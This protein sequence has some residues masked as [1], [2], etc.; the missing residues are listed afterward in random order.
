MI[1]LCEQTLRSLKGSTMHRPLFD[2]LIVRLAM[3][4]QFT[5]LRDLLA[6]AS[7][8][9]TSNPPAAGQKKK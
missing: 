3:S 4:D 7:A 5:A 9:K 6:N 8:A 1:A 2:A